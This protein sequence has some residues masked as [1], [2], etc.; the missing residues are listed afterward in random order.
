[1]SET[2][3]T[4]APAL[5]LL[6]QYLPKAPDKKFITQI[7]LSA[8]SA[9]RGSVQPELI[10]KSSEA[11]SITENEAREMFA[12]V[13][14]VI[15]YVLFEN[16]VDN[17]SVQAVLPSQ[18]HTKLKTLIASILLKNT[19]SWKEQVSNSQLSLPRL[20]KSEWRVDIK[21]SSAQL[22]SISV[23]TAVSGTSTSTSEMAP[24]ENIT[25]EASQDTLDTM[26]DG[27]GKIRDQLAV[28]ADSMQTDDS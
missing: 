16:L 13:T 23:P 7:F 14:R 18:L 28:I 10:K 26:I 1:M 4:T 25:F 9:R 3:D 22:A 2:L 12:A 17:E 24:P 21:T 5:E 11:M 20:K 19:S 6:L 8:F 15:D 27:L